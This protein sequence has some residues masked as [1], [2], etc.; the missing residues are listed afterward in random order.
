MQIIYRAIDGEEFLDKNAAEV[1]E[2]SLRDDVKMWTRGGQEASRT[3]DAYVVLLKNESS[4]DVFLGIAAE[5]NDEALSG[6]E[7]GD[8]GIFIWNEWGET[9][10]YIDPDFRKGVITAQKYIDENGLKV[11]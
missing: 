3:E 11:Y 1:Y 7:S 9:Y 4:A 10:Q 6:I 5:Q 8:L 2:K